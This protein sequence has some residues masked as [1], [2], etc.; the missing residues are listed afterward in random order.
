MVS[1]NVRLIVGLGNPGKK[2]SRTRHNVGE[3]WL[4]DLAQRFQISL[5]ESARFKGEIGRGSMLGHDIRLLFPLTYMNASG[6]SVGPFASYYKIAPAEILIVYDEVAFELG[7]C[8][9]KLGGGDN[10]HNGVKSV[11]SAL[12]NRKDFARLR[13]GVGHPG[14]AAEM[15]S[16]LTKL[17]MSTGEIES[18]VSSSIMNDTLLEY[19]LTGDW[20]KA[21]TLFHS[22]KEDIKR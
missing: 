10:G 20:E 2:F 22:L 14:N 13:I 4:R 19:V 11:M 12:G 9:I 6:E 7:T 21:M 15:V 16:Y 17:T 5:E 1:P 3:R 18:M 8:R